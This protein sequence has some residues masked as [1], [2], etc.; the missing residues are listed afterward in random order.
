[1]QIAR[2]KNKPGIS[3]QRRRQT[4]LRSAGKELP[5]YL[6]NNRVPRALISAGSIR[7]GAAAAYNQRGLYTL[8]RENFGTGNPRTPP[9]EAALLGD[10][11]LVTVIHLHAPQPKCKT[12][13][14][15]GCI[16]RGLQVRSSFWKGTPD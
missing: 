4:L 16:G 9:G 5:G 12:R 7:F 11:C 8:D 2:G 3:H 13:I 14:L 1:M 6:A 10:N 15:I